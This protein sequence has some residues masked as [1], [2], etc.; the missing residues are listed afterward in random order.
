MLTPVVRETPLRLAPCTDDPFIAGVPSGPA[1]AVA[2][3]RAPADRPGPRV[4]GPGAA[5]SYSRRKP[6]FSRTW[7]WSIAPSDR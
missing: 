3:G 6:T 4:S 2:P 7:K 1:F 5:P